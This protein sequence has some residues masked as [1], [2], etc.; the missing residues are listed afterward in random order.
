VHALGAVAFRGSLWAIGGRRGQQRQLREVWILD[1]GS[2]RWRAGPSLPKPMELLGADVTGD[3]IH[4]VWERTYQIWDASE[5]RWRQAPAPQVHRHALALFAVGGRLYAVGG[6]TTRL[7]DSAV[8]ETR[9]LP[10][11]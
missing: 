2:R 7:R 4:V 10:V 1:P 3:E 8:V 6:C 9:A 5:R 11:P